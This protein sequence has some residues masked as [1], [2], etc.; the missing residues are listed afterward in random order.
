MNVQDIITEAIVARR[1]ELCMSRY[2]LEKR[3]GIAYNHLSKIE[4]G[5]TSVTMRILDKLLDALGLELTIK[6]KN[7]ETCSIEEALLGE[8]ESTESDNTIQ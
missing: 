7:D 1:K 6:T 2:E 4:K 5:E 3:T 8:L